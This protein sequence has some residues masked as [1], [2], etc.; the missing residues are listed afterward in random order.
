M[1]NESYNYVGLDNKID[2]FFISE[3]SNGKIIKNVQFTPIKD[4]D[5]LWNLAFGDYNRGDIDDKVVSNNYDIVKVFNTIAKIVYEYSSEFPTRNI[6]VEPV[7]GK[8]KKL[9]NHIFRRHYEAINLIFDVVGTI[10]E[11]KMAYSPNIVFDEFT[12]KR[13]FLK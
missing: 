13:K 8:R 5:N 3:G 2:Y 1:L 10:G 11:E 9:Y 7:D 6:H 12:L 4:K